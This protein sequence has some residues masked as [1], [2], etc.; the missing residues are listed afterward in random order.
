[1][2]SLLE[3]VHTANRVLLYDSRQNEHDL[4]VMKVVEDGA[5]FLLLY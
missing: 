4:P 5:A 2:A 1:M 3:N